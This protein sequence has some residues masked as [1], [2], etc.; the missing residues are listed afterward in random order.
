MAQISLLSKPR[1]GK[2][3]SIISVF[4][5]SS[6][7]PPAAVEFQSNSVFMVENGPLKHTVWT[8]KRVN[9]SAFLPFLYS[10]GFR[11]GE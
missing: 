11:R 10:W 4:Y 3:M 8:S 1:G 9:S 6:N 7:T 5:S 2:G